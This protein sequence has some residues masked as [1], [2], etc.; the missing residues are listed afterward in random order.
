MSDESLIK[1]V[2]QDE[3]EALKKKES[4][5]LVVDFYATWCGPCKMIAPKL[6][7]MAKEFSD[8]MFL[9]VDVDEEEELAQSCGISAMPT[10]QLYKGGEKVGEIT[11]ANAEKLKEL[12]AE[13]K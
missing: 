3:F 1:L 4:R 10:F 6:Q 8:V 13:K 9:K 2:N 7:E 12:I 5:L 11:G